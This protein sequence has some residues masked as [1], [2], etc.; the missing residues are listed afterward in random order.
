MLSTFSLSNPGD[1]VALLVGAV[2]LLKKI[3]DVERYHDLR[4]ILL[5]SILS[6]IAILF[7]LVYGLTQSG[8]IYAP[9][10]VDEQHF[11][12]TEM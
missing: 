11:C 9:D 12:H 10:C 3:A 1:V 7:F 6:F 4:V 5:T 8:S 2:L